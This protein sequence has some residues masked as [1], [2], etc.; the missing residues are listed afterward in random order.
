ME[1]TDDQILHQLAEKVFAPERLQMLMSEFRKR[2]YN[3]QDTQ[4]ENIN[5]LNRQLKQIEGRQQ[6]LMDA[7]ETGVL[8]LDETT[9]NRAQQLKVSKEAIIIDLPPPEVHQQCQL[10][11]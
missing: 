11:R 1:K 9:Q 2:I 7:I 10:S 3:T 6:R 8:D 5:Q 4:Q